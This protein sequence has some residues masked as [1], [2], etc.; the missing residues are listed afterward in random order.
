MDS[1]VTLFEWAQVTQRIG[2]DISQRTLL[3]KEGLGLVMLI[4]Y[5]LIW[6]LGFRFLRTAV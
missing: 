1:F 3:K 4:N 2:A 6:C 5:L